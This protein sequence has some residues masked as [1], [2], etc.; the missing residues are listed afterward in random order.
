MEGCVK[1][2]QCLLHCLHTGSLCAGRYTPIEIVADV[3][4]RI[5]SATCWINPKSGKAL[6]SSVKKDKSRSVNGRNGSLK[7]RKQ[8]GL[9]CGNGQMNFY[10]TQ[11]MSGQGAFN[12][13]LHHMK[14]VE[15]HKCTNCDRRGRDDDNWHTLF[16]CLAFQLYRKDTVIILQYEDFLLHASNFRVKKCLILWN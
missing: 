9:V 5:Y 13:Y 15:S 8:S 12:G 7:A 6:Q 3:R 11:V 14:L 16:E 4:K 10:L 2:C 1:V